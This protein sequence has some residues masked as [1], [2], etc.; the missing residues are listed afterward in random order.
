[1]AAGSGERAA[2]V[3]GGAIPKQYQPIGGRAM[4]ERAIEALLVHD[5]VDSVRVV[6]GKEHDALY[7]AI[8]PAHP[9]LGPPVAGGATRQESV[10]LGLEAMAGDGPRRV[11]IHDGARPFVSAA[12]IGRVTT[13]LANAAAVVPALPVTNTLKQ[14]GSD[15]YVAATVARDGVQAAE[16]P[17]G[18][19]FAE[20]LA[21]HRKAAAQRRTF[22]DDAA[23][24]EWAGIAVAV[25]AGDP[26]NLKL[27]NAGDMV[28]ADRRL[29]GEEALR[30]GD[31]R[32]GIGYDI[33]ALGP[34]HQVKLGGVAIPHSRGLIGHSDA[35][36]VLHALTDAILG[37]LA[38]GDIG[39]HFPPTDE[40]WQGVSSDRFLAYA[41]ERVAARGGVIAHLDV[42]VVAE[43]PPVAPHRDKIRAS[44]AAI[45]AITVDRVAIKAGTN[46]GL[47]FIG[48]GEGIAAYATATL[49]LPFAAAP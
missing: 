29:A 28:A 20:I 38:E 46:E 4:L 25:V 11:L 45:C 2:G 22:T 17:Q 47:G 40:R 36:V 39:A 43:G 44:I 5:A 13:A 49:R 3:G 30:L 14:V 34:G 31:V 48:R 37:A 26:F 19:A 33:H 15:G 18:F 6:I 1:M 8:A 32:V 23:I 10:R 41:A 16:T 7:R 21:A 42:A 24:A 9:K 27:T 12:L 35:D